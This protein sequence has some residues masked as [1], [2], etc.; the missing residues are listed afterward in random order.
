MLGMCSPADHGGLAGVRLRRQRHPNG[1]WWGRGRPQLHLNSPAAG[2]AG[3]CSPAGRPARALW[4]P[5]RARRH[6]D[7]RA[8]RTAGAR[9]NPVAA[10]GDPQAAT[11]PPASAA[12][13]HSV[14]MDPAAAGACGRASDPLT[15]ASAVD[16]MTGAAAAAMLDMRSPPSSRGLGRHPFKVVTGVRIPVGAPRAIRR[17]AGALSVQGD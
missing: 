12:T 4:R 7:E 2:R 6:H 10:S 14:A 13:A 3:G 8:G 5:R 15:L 1:G 9:P 17:R 11:G 16:P